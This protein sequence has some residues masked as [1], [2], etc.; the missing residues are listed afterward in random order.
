MCYNDYSESESRHRKTKEKR[1]KRKMYVVI[2]HQKYVG[3]YFIGVADS[4]YN[5]E[6]IISQDMQN[7]NETRCELYHIEN[8]G[9]NTVHPICIERVVAQDPYTK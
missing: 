2:Y 6:R 8:V 7:S 1:G 9:L 5:A 4:I 3:S